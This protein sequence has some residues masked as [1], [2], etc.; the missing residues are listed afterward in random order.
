M[1][2]DELNSAFILHP[3]AL[4]VS[5]SDLG[6]AGGCGAQDRGDHSLIS[7]AEDNIKDA[8]DPSIRDITLIASAQQVEHHEMAIYGTLRNWA[9]LLGQDNRA[10]GAQR[11]QGRG[12]SA[13]PAAD[14]ENIC[15]HQ[16]PLL[17]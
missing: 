6:P 15:M 4:S 1:Q 10:T 11:G 7:E 13:E 16:T 5:E 12:D 9:E 17:G 14:H 2:N 8:G 3:S